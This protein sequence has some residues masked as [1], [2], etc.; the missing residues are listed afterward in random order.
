MHLGGY[1]VKAGQPVLIAAYAMHRHRQ[2]WDHPE[3]FDPLRFAPGAAPPDAWM[4]FGT[5]PR[6]CIAAQ[7][8]QAET[9]VVLAKVLARFRLEPMGPE[10]LVSLQVTTHSLNGL[11]ARVTPR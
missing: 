5:G 7:F 8:A 10:P 4:P 3:T 9:A 6:M 11:R 1:P 2:F